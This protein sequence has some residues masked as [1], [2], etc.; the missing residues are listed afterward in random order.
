MFKNPFRKNV[1]RLSKF[2][3]G[4]RVV[5]CYRVWNDSPPMFA[6]VIAV[7]NDLPESGTVWV[8]FDDGPENTPPYTDAELDYADV[9]KDWVK[10]RPFV[11]KMKQ[12]RLD[13]YRRAAGS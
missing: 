10:L 6:T 13:E 2:E 12:D 1:N 8:Q 5:Y 4:D 9:A 3:V 7:N 11:A